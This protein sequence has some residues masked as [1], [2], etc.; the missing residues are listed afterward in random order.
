M[1]SKLPKVLEK[2]VLSAVSWTFTLAVFDGLYRKSTDNVQIF[3]IIVE[4]FAVT[5]N[6][7]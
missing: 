7:L 4:D 3:F 2:V 5:L 1:V 6:R